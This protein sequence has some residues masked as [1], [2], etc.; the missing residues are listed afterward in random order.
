M[1]RVRDVSIALLWGLLAHG[2]FAIAVV[3]MWLGLHEGLEIG[4]SS[5]RGPV[6]VICDAALVI[7]FPL[8]H[9]WLL[10]RPGRALMS[11]LAP[12]GLG[13]ALAPTTFA[14]I[15]SLQALSTFVLWSPSGIVIARAEGVS[16]W[17]WNL[18]YA[19]S[20][21]FLLKALHDAGPAL[22]TGYVGWSSIVRGRQPSF[23][24]FPVH[25]TFA[26]CR[27]P[28]YLGFALTLWTGP[29]HT[30]DSLLLAVAWTAYC[31]IGPLHKERRY[32]T[33]YGEPYAAYQAKVPY[34][35]PRILR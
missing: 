13:R 35:L 12:F 30:L 25:G 14:A 29:V 33:W 15:A 20:W 3:A 6:A 11:R 24:P 5:L 2:L 19:A 16:L 10:S 32:R 23:G 4:V 7:Q 27:Q 31:A 21:G 8:L 9:S 22:Q 34:F 26:R 18:A 28:V 17:A 1:T